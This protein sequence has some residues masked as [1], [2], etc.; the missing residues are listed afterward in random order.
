MSKAFSF[1]FIIKNKINLFFLLL[2][3]EILYPS[4]LH[5]IN[6]F[7]LLLKIIKS[8]FLYVL[9]FI[10][11]SMC[12]LYGFISIIEHMGMLLKSLFAV[13]SHFPDKCFYFHFHNE[14]ILIEL[15]YIVKGLVFVS[16]Y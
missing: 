12:K 2:Q 8:I 9:N 1:F 14:F 10:F 7:V 6:L 11:S 3:R 4:F 13:Y 5:F 15:F 16:F